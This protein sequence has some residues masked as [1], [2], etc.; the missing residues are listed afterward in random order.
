MERW[1]VE[2]AVQPGSREASPAKSTV[3]WAMSKSLGTMLQTS[4]AK[5]YGVVKP[6]SPAMEPVWGVGQSYRHRTEQ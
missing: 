3:L 1:T 5:W 2:I 6:D 4:S